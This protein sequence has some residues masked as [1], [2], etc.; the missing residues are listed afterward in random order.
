V[1]V[2]DHSA[3][4]S[5]IESVLTKNVSAS[6]QL[7]LYV[8][9]RFEY[10]SKLLSLNILD[11]HASGKNNPMLRETYAELAQQELILIRNIVR[12]GKSDGEFNVHSVDKTAEALLHIMQ[13]LRWR[14]Q[15]KVESPRIE[16][17]EYEHLKNEISYVAE[18][19]IR[20]IR[21]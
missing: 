1:I 6:E 7:R 10:F 19:F 8:V 5:N 18:I 13:G 11:L 15:Q 9:K 12:R 16:P 3:F 17:K 2:G 21:K 20:G 4:R 14:F